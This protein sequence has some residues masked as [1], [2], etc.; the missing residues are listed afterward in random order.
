LEFRQSDKK[1]PLIGG[2]V[3][4]L[5]FDLKENSPPFVLQF[6]IMS[7][8]VSATFAGSHKKKGKEME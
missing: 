7:H 4:I 1:E 5:D 6:S 2:W 8:Y 3:R